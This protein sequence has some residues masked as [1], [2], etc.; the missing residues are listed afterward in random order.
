MD[1]FLLIL[2]FDFCVLVSFGLSS[3]EVIEWGC[4]ASIWRIGIGERYSLDNG[5]RDSSSL[6]NTESN[7]D[8]AQDNIR[9]GFSIEQGL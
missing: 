2:A 9:V 1:H 8:T 7:V 6:S 5:G 3:V 4:K